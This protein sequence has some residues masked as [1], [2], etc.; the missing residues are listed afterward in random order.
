MTSVT[1]NVGVAL[2]ALASVGVVEA[3]RAATVAQLTQKCDIA[4]LKAAGKEVRAKMLCYARAKN[5]AAPVEATCLTNHQTKADATINTAGG[6]CGGSASGIDAAVDG[7]VSVFLTDDPGT[8]A[9]PA[10]S[11][12]A[13]ANGAKGEL[14]CQAKEVTTPGTF[15][16]CD[17]TEDGKTTALLGT[18][19]RGTPCAN[20]TAVMADIDSCDAA[21]DAVVTGTCGLP[22]DPSCGDSFTA[23]ASTADVY[24]SC[25]FDH[26]GSQD[27]CIDTESCS[28]SGC[29]SDSDC[30]SG[31]VCVTE[32]YLLSGCCAVTSA[33]CTCPLPGACPLVTKWGSPGRG[34][35]QFRSVG[36]VA[37]DGSGNVFVAEED[38][39]RIQKF[40]S[41]GTFL[42][43]FGWGVQDGMPTFEICTS[44]CQAGIPG[45]GDGQFADPF[46]VAVDGSGDVF[47]GERVNNRIQ[48]FTNTGTFLTKW[49]TAGSGDG[50]FNGPRGVA[51]DGSGNVFV[52]DSYND[53]IEKFTNTGAFL[54]T[55]GWGV[56]DGMAAFETCTSGCQAGIAGSGDG[57]F[58]HPVGVAVDG[59]GNV[60]VADPTE[61]RISKFDNTGNFDTKWASGVSN[62][63][64][65]VAV[66]VNGNVFASD[67][68]LDHIDEFTNTGAFVRTLG[69]TGNG[70]IA[71]DGNENVFVADSGNDRIQKFGCP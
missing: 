33:T 17:T 23:P 5:A 27:A 43:T 67:T 1:R 22:C 10:R 60:F 37:V 26:V 45:S 46:G 35:G 4:K 59:S 34:D 38:N 58:G 29:G 41:T 49:G 12:K 20:V 64:S 19:G 44:G 9:C 51:V 70:G 57:E 65:F 30:P 48:T 54:L 28:Y 3:A 53:R 39:H 7:C 55:F 14:A 61:N 66:D 42:L 18:A 50:Q 31:Q 40:T 69:C 13:I 68:Q 16:T 56:Q 36:G 47:V 24:H 6:A 25:P 2:V 71:V 63:L 8:G 15:P 32:G 21:I 11:A 52:A 62:G